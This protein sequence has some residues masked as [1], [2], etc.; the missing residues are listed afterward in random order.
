MYRFFCVLFLYLCILQTPSSA[1]SFPNDCDYFN[2]PSVDCVPPFQYYTGYNT[3]FHV[4][5]C[6]L[7][8]I[9]PPGTIAHYRKEIKYT[10]NVASSTPVQDPNGTTIFFNSTTYISHISFWW[11]GLPGLSSTVGQSLFTI[12]NGTAANGIAQSS[13]TIGMLRGLPCVFLN[14]GITGPAGCISTF[15]NPP[16]FTEETTWKKYDLIWVRSTYCYKVYV[17]GLPVFFSPTTDG[18]TGDPYFFCKGGSQYPIPYNNPLGSNSPQ[19][20][21]YP[22]TVVSPL[23][24]SDT[25]K[26][27]IQDL[28]IIT[29]QMTVLNGYPNSNYNEAFIDSLLAKSFSCGPRYGFGSGCRL[30]TNGTTAKT[31]PIYFYQTAQSL[32]GVTQQETDG[33][34]RY[35]LFSD[36]TFMND[37]LHTFGY[38]S[39][40]NYINSVVNSEMDIYL[41]FKLKI[42]AQGTLYGAA[43]TPG[44]PLIQFR[45]TTN[46]RVF[47]LFYY[48]LQMYLCSSL[49][50]S[51]TDTI[52]ITSSD[53]LC[54]VLTNALL[55]AGTSQLRYAEP[56][57]T[58]LR[59]AFTNNGIMYNNT[60]IQNTQFS[61]SWLTLSTSY[62][63]ITI[64]NTTIIPSRVS[65]NGLY[66][67][68]WIK[69]LYWYQPPAVD[70]A[71]RNSSRFLNLTIYDSRAPLFSSLLNTSFTNWNFP[72]PQ[73][74]RMLYNSST[75]NGYVTSPMTCFG[76]CA[77][78]NQVTPG[79]LYVSTSNSTTAA[80]STTKTCATGFANINVGCQTPCVVNDT[81]ADGLCLTGVQCYCPFGVLQT[82]N[83]TC[84]CPDR[85]NQF[86]LGC[87][88]CTCDNVT[89]TCSSGIKGTGAC[90]CLNPVTM[91]NYTYIN[92]TTFLTTT[93]CD[94]TNINFN[95][96]RF[97]NN[98]CPLYISPATCSTGFYGNGTLSCPST[99][100]RIEFLAS[101]VAYCQCQDPTRQ[102]GFN[103]TDCRCDY[104]ARCA[105]GING[106]GACTCPSFMTQKNTTSERVGC[107]CPSNNQ[108]GPFCTTCNCTLGASCYS[109]VNGT[110]QCY[111]PQSGYR[112]NSNGNGC[113][114][115]TNFY[116][117]DGSGNCI[118][119][120]FC[121]YGTL[122]SDGR[123]GNGSCITQPAYNCTAFCGTSNAQLVCKD[124]LAYGMDC[125]GRCPDCNFGSSC[126]SGMTGNGVCRKNLGFVCVAN[127]DKPNGI[128]ECADPDAYGPTCS[129]SCTA[130]NCRHGTYCSN[131]YAGNGTCIILPEFKLVVGTEANPQ[132]DCKDNNRWGFLCDQFCPSYCPYGSR[133]N[134]GTAGTG[135]CVPLPFFEFKT[136]SSLD[137]ING[138]YGVDCTSVCQS[139]PTGSYC[140]SGYTSTGQCL[141][142]PNFIK[143]N[144]TYFDCSK[145]RYGALCQNLCPSCP[146][147]NS[148]CDSGTSGS[149]QCLC[150]S[151]TIK[152]LDGS[153]D[154]PAGKSGYNCSQTC[155]AC[156][157]NSTCS[158]GLSGTNTCVCNGN[159]TRASPASPC[160]CPPGYYG[161]M[162]QFSCGTCLG[163]STC[164]S[165]VNGTGLCVC[166]VGQH[167]EGG[168]CVCDKDR[169]GTNC[170]YTCPNCT[171]YDSNMMCSDGRNGT[172][173][174]FCNGANNLVLFQQSVWSLPVCQCKKG[175]MGADCQTPSPV[176]C[177][178]SF[179]YYYYPNNTYY[180]DC[181]EG[182]YNS[183]CSSI[184][185]PCQMIDENSECEYG[186]TGSGQCKCKA[187]F[188]KNSYGR[189]VC[190]TGKY[191]VG[192]LQTCKTCYDPAGFG[193]CNDGETGDGS[194]ICPS[195]TMTA[196]YNSTG[197]FL[198]CQCRKGYYGLNCSS[199]CFENCPTRD[200]NSICNDGML[201][202][203][204]CKCTGNSYALSVVAGVATCQCQPGYYGTLCNN[205]CRA[206]YTMYDPN[207]YCVD[208]V[209]GNGTVA[210]RS[211]YV[212]KSYFP[213]VCGCPANRSG[214]DCSI[215]DQVCTDRNAVVNTGMNGDGKCYCNI[216]TLT[217]SN[218]G[219][220]DVTCICPPNTFGPSCLTTCPPC[221]SYHPD[222]YCLEGLTGLGICVC[223]STKLLTLNYS[224]TLLTGTPSCQCKTGYGGDPCTLLDPPPPCPANERIMTRSD[225]SYYCEC[226]V[227]FYG[228]NC[229]L[230]CPSTT[231]L[232][233]ICRDGKNG[234]GEIVCKPNTNLQY[235]TTGSGLQPFCACSNNWY[236]ANC[237]QFCNQ[238]A[239]SQ[240]PYK[241]CS[242]NGACSCKF[243]LMPYKGYC[244]CGTVLA[245]YDVFGATCDP[246]YPN[247]FGQGYPNPHVKCDKG[248]LGTGAVTCDDP[249]RFELVTNATTGL[250]ECV[251]KHDN[252]WGPECLPCPNCN[253]S[254]SRVTCNRNTGF[255]TC[256]PTHYLRTDFA[257]GF[258]YCECPHGFTGPDCETRIIVSTSPC[259]YANQIKT[260]NL[261]DS[262]FICICQDAWTGPDC[263]IR[264]S[265]EVCLPNQIRVVNYNDSTSSCQC[266]YGYKGE[267]CTERILPEPCGMNQVRLVNLTDGN[268]YC[269]CIDG[270]NGTNC[271][272]RII[273][274][275][276]GTNKIR[277]YD[278]ATGST[279]CVCTQGWQGP[280][281]LD[282]IVVPECGINQIRIITDFYYGISECVC[283]QGWTGPN[284][285]Q[286]VIIPPCSTNQVRV[287][288]L[289]D[290][291]SYCD[292]LYGWEGPFCEQRVAS[293]S[294]GS[295]AVRIV[296]TIDSTTS[297]QCI[298]GRTGVNCTD[299]IAPPTCPFPNQIRV[300]HPYDI[301]TSVC[302]CDSFYTG[303][304]C[305][306]YK[307]SNYYCNNAFAYT[308]LN[309]DLRIL[310][311][312]CKAGWGGPNCETDLGYSPCPF[313][314][315]QLLVLDPVT[316]QA[317]CKCNSNW[318]GT[319]CEQRVV[320]ITCGQNQIAVLNE[321]TYDLQCQCS[322]GYTGVDCLSKVLPPV[323][324]QNYVLSANYT[325]GEVLCKCDAQRGGEN[326]T[327]YIPSVS[328]PGE[329]SI[330]V[331]DQTTGVLSCAC[332]SLWS[333][334]NCTVPSVSNLC[335][336]NANA[337][338]DPYTLNIDCVCMV[339]WQGANCDDPVI[340][341]QLPV[342][343]VCNSE[344]VLSYNSLTSSFECAC[345]FATQGQICNSLFFLPTCQPYQQFVFHRPTN[346]FFC[347]CPEGKI[348][349]FC[350]ET[351]TTVVEVL[352][353]NTITLNNT[354]VVNNTV[355]VNNTI[356][357][358]NTVYVDR[359]IEFNNTIYVERVV[360]VN[361]TVFVDREILVNNTIYLNN[362]VYFNQ[363]I[364][365]NETQYINNTV[366]VNQTIFVNTTEYVNNTVYVNQTV[367]LN[368]E[369]VVY[370]NNTV[371]ISNETVIIINGTANANDS[372]S[373]LPATNTANDAIGLS[374]L[375][376]GE[377]AAVVAGYTA[378]TIGVGV[379]ISG[380]YYMFAQRAATSAIMQV[381]SAADEEEEEGEDGK[382]NKKKKKATKQKKN[383]KKQSSGKTRQ[384]DVPLME[385]DNHLYNQGD[386]YQDMYSTN[387]DHDL[388][389][390]PD[391]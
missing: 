119:C 241:T 205:T 219:T 200:G 110:G 61:P 294:C 322:P 86:G 176:E 74:G 254:D 281:C 297:C 263:S 157:S 124:P 367:V 328:C 42:P 357:V 260:V 299:K 191:G 65:K 366:Y 17:N 29:N 190:P 58:N 93:A 353:N 68:E 286:R 171:M 313:P 32:A 289:T 113:D 315:K 167:F 317:T 391:M 192:C 374:S 40:I 121:P 103:C 335:P 151:P 207:A 13:I 287:V 253:V 194:C 45:S 360:E 302:I 140:Q 139:C 309:P 116:G 41:S 66:V 101:D 19:N 274:P 208:G 15:F 246:C 8:A 305:E 59:I 166:P 47:S 147:I 94:C 44:I 359:I 364:Y 57:Q 133:C 346:Q 251:C 206:N 100:K 14:G 368:N 223:N 270:Y 193:V 4:D 2:S 275:D 11:R 320:P 351:L 169:W 126:S 130:S 149:G 185:Q 182:F 156:D 264:K 189:C 178:P 43:S 243:P 247:W 228:S 30:P 115:P 27:Q 213:L 154:C 183:T 215:V 142:L 390:V 122:C 114:C 334:P 25:T 268:S 62:T 186:F 88:R 107:D 375:T 389:H 212:I 148:Y 276:C 321:V 298:Y 108:Y 295:N 257:Q 187:G 89:S 307:G 164:Q 39:L 138:R 236:G 381:A 242:I 196:H 372:L 291:S 301:T 356:V 377:Q 181:F 340:P 78:Y 112:L 143:L 220:A 90:N 76:N 209:M 284:C 304:E 26:W 64:L 373:A 55:Y 7:T 18:G 369:T 81:R 354:I 172:G 282:R 10:T 102:F 111:C 82:N 91:S 350:N 355:L 358:N 6:N 135:A 161:G 279:N 198:G 231:L 387:H 383:K 245:G 269:N 52:S 128:Y 342:I 109:G 159:L 330:T 70:I 233:S 347:A 195:A 12:G 123:S 310:E 306:I 75:L 344:Q 308:V 153:C 23:S 388:H 303:V 155:P 24:S 288:N 158:T 210:C 343:P 255:C 218:N 259:P 280:D 336:V 232:N 258:P 71:T 216:H 333:G 201:G 50:N 376:T 69:D 150:K 238:T 36:V 250:Y 170:Q 249:T 184:C 87:Q 237:D 31:T 300:V 252:H 160:D 188:V 53:N 204:Q 349:S 337:V 79:S 21:Q 211:P 221:A 222:M 382:G 370:I 234:T 33:M 73:T 283:I 125:T 95:Y 85:W 98:T 136:P 117:N 34:K 331:V 361:N 239:C 180:C 132:Y 177:A 97:C 230:P 203:G 67:S 141:A 267:N 199:M 312:V 146:D 162:C 179:K 265:A 261:T 378:G 379:A 96:G 235:I 319:S 365:I 105:G 314:D 129:G 362:T 134:S 28:Y 22:L 327:T 385:E 9:L 273:L 51:G 332:R 38:T 380:V 348:G 3:D 46:R 244:E 84:E 290:G 277:V 60:Y 384:E 271:E 63:T 131:G 352:V 285:D 163:G 329:N 92:T 54:T 323:C 345:I 202:D 56:M 174:C 175:W 339:G 16:S 293:P 77:S 325:T 5:D 99:Q 248:S 137:C 173:S 227:G 214:I 224:S 49:Y 217:S 338:V 168:I 272:N 229:S 197:F 324:P 35:L 311:C 72:Y 20:M 118:A 83:K 256:P 120:N 316:R 363:T 225:G 266:I 48:N 144:S 371:Y 278:M 1:Q 240:D 318:T 165:G 152:K 226:P 296:N 262:S 106:N 104:P 341:P 292:C 127:C 386:P 37:D 80:L 145:D 326:C